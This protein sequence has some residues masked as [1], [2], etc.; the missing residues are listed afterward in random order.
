MR[1]ALALLLLVGSLAAED[2]L[3]VVAGAPF[4]VRTPADWI[5]VAPTTGTAFIV[6]SPP[7]AG[8]GGGRATE[9]ARIAVTSA[10]LQPG[11]DGDA[12][13]KR[14]L[15]D[16]AS[17]TPGFATV[18]EPTAV[19]LLGRRWWRARYRFST[20]LLAWEQTLLTIA[21]DGVGWC[22][23]AGTGRE[24]VER[25]AGVLGEPLA[26]PQGDAPAR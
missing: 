25:W 24:H 21:A 18:G 11:E 13:A 20:G 26:P 10:R 12:F 7:L 3:H 23:T 16:L 4:R 2:R 17:L 5:A 6:E 22:V 14:C 1:P 15:A 8:D 19:H 9:R